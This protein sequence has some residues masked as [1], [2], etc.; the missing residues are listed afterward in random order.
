MTRG[1]LKIIPPS[2]A[3][4]RGTAFGQVLAQALDEPDFKQLLFE[5][6]D[7]VPASVLPFL[8]REWSMEEFIEPGMS[9]LVVRRLLKEAFTLHQM[10]ASIRGVRHGLK[11]L[12]MRVAWKQWFQMTPPGAPGTHTITVYVSEYIFD[13]QD[14]LLDTRA[15]RAALRM[16]AGMKRWS[17]H[18]TFQVGVSIGSTLGVATA[19]QAM[20]IGQFGGTASTPRR[21]RSRLGMATAAQAMQVGVFG[22]QATTPRHGRTSLTIAAAAQAIQVG[23]F[24]AHATH[25]SMR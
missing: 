18:E 15:Q 21:G 11:M 1:D 20:Q 12:G 14:A 19:A 13:G 25:R 7:T 23:A 22:G 10:K 4:A 8:V 2:V 17:Q 6:I 5:R 24:Q 3:D 16:I 9:E